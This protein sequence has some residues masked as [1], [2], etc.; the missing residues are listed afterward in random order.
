MEEHDGAIQDAG[1]VYENNDE[2]MVDSNSVTRAVFFVAVFTPQ[3]SRL[4]LGQTF[5]PRGHLAT[6]GQI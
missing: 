5:S 3:Q 4:P 1:E 2:Q 6:C